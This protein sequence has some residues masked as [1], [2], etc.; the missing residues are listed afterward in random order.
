MAGREPGGDSVAGRGYHRGSGGDWQLSDD[1]GTR[2]EKL[3]T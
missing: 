2:R 3:V 1:P